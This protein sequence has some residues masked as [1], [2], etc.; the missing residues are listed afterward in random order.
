MSGRV[1]R[2]SVALTDRY[3]VKRIAV[4]PMMCGLTSC[5][6][7]A[8]SAGPRAGSP[9]SYLAL[10]DSPAVPTFPRDRMLPRVRRSDFER[11]FDAGGGAS[12]G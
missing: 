1:D 4:A 10:F 2:L 11:A 8:V 5:T 12:L 3:R 7:G 6:C 9:S